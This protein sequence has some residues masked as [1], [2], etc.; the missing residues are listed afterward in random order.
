[1]AFDLFIFLSSDSKN[2]ILVHVVLQSKAENAYLYNYK[3][4]RLKGNLIIDLN[5]G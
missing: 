2:D 1:M 5:I 4:P 3:T